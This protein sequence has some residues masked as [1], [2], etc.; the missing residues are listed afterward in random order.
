MIRELH[1]RNYTIVDEVSLELSDGFNVI[2]GETGAG[3]SILVGALSLVLG[4]RASPDGV[5]LGSKEAL[6]EAAFD[7]FPPPESAMSSCSDT[8]SSPDDQESSPDLGQ[9]VLILK[10]VLSDTGR[11]RA[12]INGAMATLST[13]KARGQR[14]VEVHGQQGQQHLPDRKWQRVLLDAFGALSHLQ[15]EYGEAYG[16]WSQL[17]QEKEALETKIAEAE[18]QASFLSFQLGEIREARL[19]TEEEAGLE[20]EEHPLKH[21]EAMLSTVQGAYSQLSD[22]GGLLS[23]LD[24]TGQAIHKLHNIT[25]D[26][27]PEITLWEQSKIHLK[28]LSALLRSRFQDEAYLPERLEEITSRL[29]VIH[30]LKRKYQ[31]SVPE[32]LI[33][34]QTLENELSAFSANEMRR[35]EIEEALKSAK[36]WLFSAAESLSRGRAESSI[37]LQSRVKAEL[38]ALGMEKTAFHIRLNRTDP[39]LSGMDKIEFMIALPGEVPRELDKIASGGELS[40]L[41]L[42][43]KVVLAEVDPVPTLLFDEIDAGVGGG[44]AERV[45]RRLFALSSHHQVLC[46]T[47]LPQIAS[48][49]DHHYFVEKKKQGG[50]IVTGIRELSYPERIE[51]LARMLGGVTITDLTRRHAEEMIGAR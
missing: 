31:R 50:R 13:L 11:S 19:D 21:W 34:Q 9:E 42:A 2:T 30:Q 43:L 36:A 28:E 47:H 32:L 20:K 24:E 45:G 44:I 33:Y 49:A 7:P 10:R 22:E 40:R 18:K 38:D 6:L 27:S 1:I 4:E 26:A 51:E 16:E 25:D 39:G 15:A 8:V 29:Y 37:K 14:L 12:Y 3:K 41:M 23:Q 48:L 5:R 46:I 35:D 17:I